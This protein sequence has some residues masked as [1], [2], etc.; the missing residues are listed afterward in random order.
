[1]SGTN[2]EVPKTLSTIWQIPWHIHSKEARNHVPCIF[3]AWQISPT[4]DFIDCFHPDP[5]PPARHISFNYTLPD[6]NFSKVSYLSRRGFDP[7][8]AS[9]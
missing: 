8:P 2:E 3:I 7:S 1:M 9:I 5:V 6:P 4:G